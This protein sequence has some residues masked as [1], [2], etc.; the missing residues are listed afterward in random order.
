MNLVGF[1]SSPAGRV[2]RAILGLAMIAI[3][4]VLGGGWYIL[5][6]VGLL[7]LAAGG[8]RL[9]PDR[10]AAA[11]P[12]GRQEVPRTHHPAVTQP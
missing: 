3:G 9:L 4:V 2:V 7:P 12:D 10:A 1:L 11:P 5:A 8:F 6:A